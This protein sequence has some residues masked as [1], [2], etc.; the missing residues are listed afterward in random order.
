MVDDCV[1]SDIPQVLEEEKLAENSQRLGEILRAELRQLPGDII[2]E[3]RG[4][5]LLN[6]IIID[7]RKWYNSIAMVGILT[8]EILLYKKKISDDVDLQD[9]YSCST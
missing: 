3:V 8:V 5:G 4:K 7:K 9:I 6:A 2:T 1:V